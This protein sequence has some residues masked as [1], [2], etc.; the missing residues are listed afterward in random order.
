MRHD[1]VEAG[2]AKQCQEIKD[3]PSLLPAVA[4]FVFSFS[5]EANVISFGATITVME[6]GWKWQPAVILLEKMQLTGVQARAVEHDLSSLSALSR[7][8]R[9]RQ[10]W[11]HTM[12]LLAH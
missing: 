7:F 11:S 5:S 1:R 8:T 2:F 9:F 12:L 10:T 4:I 6:K 3:C